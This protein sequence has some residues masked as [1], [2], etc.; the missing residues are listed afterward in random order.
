[1]CV[2]LTATQTHT[3]TRTHAH[4]LQ[5]SCCHGWLGILCCEL[6][7]PF[8][9]PHIGSRKGPEQ[10]LQSKHA[11][12]HRCRWECLHMHPPDGCFSIVNQVNVFIPLACLWCISSCYCVTDYR[13][14]YFFEADNSVSP[15]YTSLLLLL[16]PNPVYTLVIMMKNGWRD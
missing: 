15:T 7:F 10:K 12:T 1:M 13:S 5:T 2:R 3:Y 14:V 6:R 8:I 16:H 9:V 4:T 11:R